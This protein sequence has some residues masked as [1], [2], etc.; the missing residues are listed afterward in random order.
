MTQRVRIEW[1][2]SNGR[3]YGKNVRVGD[4][5]RTYRAILE[6]TISFYE[7]LLLK[8][9]PDWKEQRG[10]EFEKVLGENHIGGDAPN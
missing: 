1:K 7:K 9:A 4:E 5:A 8:Y 2:G 6:Q 3:T 10:A